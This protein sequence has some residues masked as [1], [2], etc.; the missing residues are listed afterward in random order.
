MLSQPAS[1]SCHTL[2]SWEV[3]GGLVPPFALPVFKKHEASFPHK[4]ARSLKLIWAGFLLG[5]KSMGSWVETECFVGGNRGSYI[6]DSPL[7]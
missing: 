5:P 3:C 6:L 7:L 1:S 4:D 2:V